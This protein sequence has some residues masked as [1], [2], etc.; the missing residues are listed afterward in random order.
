MTL[1]TLF[2][3]HLVMTLLVAASHFAPEASAADAAVQASLREA[4]ILH[5]LVREYPLAEIKNSFSTSV[6]EVRGNARMN[7]SLLKR[8]LFL[9]PP[10]GETTAATATYSLRFPRLSEGEK[11]LFLFAVGLRPGWRDA[12]GSG[13][14]GV[15]FR[16]L[17]NADKVFEQLW[18]RDEWCFSAVDLSRHAGR[19][20]RLTLVCDRNKN[21]SADWALWG[22]PRILVIRRATRR[23]GTAAG[24][25]LYMFQPSPAGEIVARWLALGAAGTGVIRPFPNAERSVT[26]WFPAPPSGKEAV[27]LPLLKLADGSSPTLSRVSVVSYAPKVDLVSVGQSPAIVTPY[28]SFRVVATVRNVGEGDLRPDHRVRIRLGVPEG[29]RLAKGQ[30]ATETL[31]ELT[32]GREMDLSWRLAASSRPGRGEF[33]LTMGVI[34]L[35]VFDVIV[36][37]TGDGID[38]TN[39][40]ADSGGLHEQRNSLVLEKGSTRLAFVRE[41]RRFQYGTVLMKVAERW[42]AVG[43]LTPFGE[44]SV[45]LDA[46]LERRIEMQPSHH[47]RLAE[48]DGKALSDGQLGVRF[49]DEFSDEDSVR[50]RFQQSFVLEAGSPWIEVETS[51][52]PA[53][54]RE[55]V[56]FSAPRLLAGDGSFGGSKD[57]A[58]FPGLEYLGPNEPSSSTRD[59]AFPLNLRSMPHPLRVTIPLMAVRSGDAIIGLSW[60]VHQKWHGEKTMPT[61]LFSSPNRFPSQDNHLMALVVPT[62][63]DYIKEGTLDSTRTLPLGT[64]ETVKTRTSLLLLPEAGDITEALVAWVKRYGLPAPTWPRDFEE[65]TALCRQGFLQ[66]VWNKSAQGWSHCVGWAPGPY[67]GYCTLLNMDYFLSGDEKVRQTL[68]ERIDLVVRNCLKRYGPGSLWRQDA[69]HILTG[70]LPFLEGQVVESVSAWERAM[71]GLVAGQSPDGSWRW[72]PDERRATLGKPGDTTSGMCARGAL[73]LLREAIVTGNSTHI[74]AGLKTLELLDGYRIPTGAQEW[75]CPIYAPDVLA[76]AYAVRAFVLAYETT[77]DNRYLEKASFWA[78]TGIP[79]HYLWGVGESMPQMLYAGIPIFGATFYTH[80]W[81]GRPVQWCSL[82]YAY[83]LLRLSR[84]DHS[85]DWRRLAEGITASA[86]WQQYAEGKSKGCYPDSWDLLENHPNPADINPENI[87]LNTLALKGYDPGLKHKVLNGGDKPIFITAIAEMLSAEA[88]GDTGAVIRLKFFPGA[89]SYLLIAGLPPRCKPEVT[90]NATRLEL[91]RDI[92]SVP[93]GWLYLPEKNWLVVAVTHTQKE[94][95]LRIRW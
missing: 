36:S 4:E 23:A 10:S 65:E 92:D 39:L 74:A 17:V 20:I 46:G 54:P 81:L 31:R 35:R 49:F 9:H 18:D 55:V 56:T 71:G 79:F 93:N 66:S 16:V 29:F 69:C 84:Y 40:D 34:V 33:A 88:E 7:Y 30:A 37:P 57:Q 70:E 91:A 50:W 64:N 85:F 53:A 58:V 25:S 63:P 28:D 62:V 26:A 83:S 38:H 11:L 60:D 8:Y 1:R 94:D 76:A 27:A 95:S 24:N 32:A 12:G 47:T 82:V 48:L 44:L 86:T 80:T 22:D 5:D 90:L 77:G 61:P 78:K 2:R 67:P 87:L 13:A 41:G 73:Q 6:G 45:K 72:R 75:E 43:H 19:T 14:D 52:T 89:K 51:L 15:V 21:S 59:L 3:G 68:R 42:R